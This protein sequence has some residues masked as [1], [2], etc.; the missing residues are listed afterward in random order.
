MRKILLLIILIF[1][2]PL[3]ISGQSLFNSLDTDVGARSISMGESFVAL[4]NTSSGSFYNPATI[5]EIPGFASSFNNRYLDWLRGTEQLHFIAWNMVINSPYG[6]FCPFYNRFNFGEVIISTPE[7]I[8]KARVYDHTYG[9]SYSNEIY[10]QLYGGLTLKTYNEVTDYIICPPGWNTSSNISQPYLLDFGIL[11]RQ[12]GFLSSNNIADEISVGAALH[13]FGTDYKRENHYI[14]LP[15]YARVGFAYTFNVI[16]ECEETL[17]PFRFILTGEYYNHINIWK[18]MRDKRD[19]W[20]AG[21][22]ATFLEVVS[23]RMGGYVQPFYSIYGE[24]G[25]PAFRYGFGLNAPLRLTGI[26][27]PIAV[28]FDFAAIPLNYVSLHVSEQLK[29]TLTAFSLEVKYIEDLF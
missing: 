14:R 20:K 4:T 5:C 7:G 15:R 21:M 1:F 9:L 22:E 18:T 27:T 2:Y 17:Q 8:G 11:Y 29:R 24:K 26:N 19:Y 23:L 10:N 16:K 25:L 28:S 6:Y 3:L 13:N 12:S